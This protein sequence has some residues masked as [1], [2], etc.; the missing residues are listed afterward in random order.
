MKKCSKC[1]ITKSKTCFQKCSK[2]KDGLRSECREC[3]IKASKE[4]YEKNREKI[5]E[6]VREKIKTNREEFRRRAHK[7]YWKNPEI[8]RKRSVLWAQ[9]HRDKTRERSIRWK[10]NNSDKVKQHEK[11][12]YLKKQSNPTTRIRHNVATAISRSIQKGQ[13]ANRHWCDLVG[14]TL[15]ELK[16]HLE[17]QFTEDMTWRNYGKYWHIDHIIP[18]SV[19][20]FS[21]TEDIDFKRCWELSNLRPMLA[22]DNIIKSNKL[23]R[24]FQPSLQIC[25]G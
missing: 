4:Y 21:R 5:L 19:F 7:Y 15:D 16:H 20:N 10:K 1:N 22:R 6:Q 2:H 17:G 24:P 25:A 13:K 9:K 18:L 8:V 11:R 3:S 12:S 14:Y 23:V